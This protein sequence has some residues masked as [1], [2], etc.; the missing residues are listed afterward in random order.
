MSDHKL[1]SSFA[2]SSLIHLML[3]VPVV[4]LMMRAQVHKLQ[5]VPVQL[6]DV[7]LV[8]ETNKAD[9]TPPQPQATKPKSQNISAPK[10]LSKAP[11]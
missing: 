8:E 7:P 6:V 3:V 10:L 2:V 9:L 11:I 5:L 1:L 4:S